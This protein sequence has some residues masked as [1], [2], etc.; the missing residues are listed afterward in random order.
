MGFPVPPLSVQPLVENAVKHGVGK[1]PGGGTIL[2]RTEMVD[3]KLRLT[4]HDD[5]VG[6]DPETVLK[7]EQGENT[8]ENTADKTERPMG[9]GLRNSRQRFRLV[10]NADFQVESAPG[11]GTT[12]TVTIPLPEEAAQL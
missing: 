4:I 9:I 11:Q 12:V 5:G 8:A 1:K 3:G 6:F 10:M 7:E 2:I